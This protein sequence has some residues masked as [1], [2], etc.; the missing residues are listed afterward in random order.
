MAGGRLD[1]T[2]LVPALDALTGVEA[3]QADAAVLAL[4]NGI[5]E[6]R[7][8]ERRDPGLLSQCLLLL[9]RRPTRA[10]L[11]FFRAATA[12]EAAGHLADSAA[13]LRGDALRA[14]HALEPREARFEAVRLLAE[15]RRALS[16][17]PLR[18][19]VEVLGTLGDDAALVLACE[20][21]LAG[22]IGLAVTALGQMTAEVPPS[23]FWRIGAAAI[24]DR[25][26]D[27]VLT[28]TD[29]ITAG[30][31]A[32]LLPGFAAALSDV[33]DPDLMRAVLLSLITARL[34]GI[35]ALLATVVDG[36]PRRSLEAV[37]DALDVAR[38]PSR[39]ALVDRLQARLRGG[40]APL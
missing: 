32:D 6:G 8:G 18:A 11:P 36:A 27:A 39:D 20:T 7:F 22:D 14:L 31:R 30:S 21:T 2:R 4:A 13:R 1:R 9:A 16:G 29:L 3:P 26:T 5:L 10:A 37:G 35:E 17:E 38:V 25:F 34:D 23:T 19:A 15:G 28:L 40:D 24:G 12:V 33:G